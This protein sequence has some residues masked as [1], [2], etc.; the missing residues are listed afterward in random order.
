METVIINEKKI[1]WLIVERGFKIP[2]FN[3][4][5]ELTEVAGREGATLKD[6]NLKHYEFDLPLIAL[7]DYI[8]KRKDHDEILNELVKFFNYEEPVKL[9]LSTK[10]WYWKAMFDGP[11]ELESVREGFISFTI[12][13]ILLD[14]YKY[15]AKEYTS[16]AYS[17]QIAIKNDGN[18]KT[19][20]VVKAT[21]LKDSTSFTITKNDEDYFMIGQE[22]ALKE[23]KD[24][25]PL[26]Y[27]TFMNNVAG[28]SYLPNGEVMQDN[29]TSAFAVGSIRS[30]GDN[31]TVKDYGERPTAGWHGPAVKR[32]LPR[33]VQDFEVTGVIKIFTRRQGVGKGFYHL[34]DEMGNIVCSF[35][36][37]D[38]TNSTT[39][40]K[41]Y[42]SMHNEYQER[43]EWYANAGNW[44]YDNAYVYLKVKRVGNTWHLKTWHYYTDE[45][46]KKRITSRASKTFND[47]GNWYTAKIAQVGLHASKHT[48]YEAL[49]VYFN[50]FHF[51]ELLQGDGIPYIIKKGDE[52]Y[53]DMQQELV[54]I[55]NEDALH[56]KTFGSD[57]FSVD[58]GV[59]ELF[60]L[61]QGTFDTKVSWINRFY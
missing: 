1:P 24:K 41:A 2:S 34:Y 59:S 10:N 53:I 12:K 52:V 35:G 40:V 16:P 58:G 56:E 33:L 7:N 44:A 60:V 50:R 21:A 22:D 20:P 8:Y 51:Y 3:F 13:V 18:A 29:I 42:F 54:L 15:E 31:V 61:P 46:G 43:F 30:T 14:P 32:S 17:D 4:E 11:I 39:N 36:L 45:D 9:Q 5:S 6:R 38:A 47:S 48:R 28:W 25:S 26:V 57:Y 27:G 19:Y 37:L 55:N 23:V 49:P